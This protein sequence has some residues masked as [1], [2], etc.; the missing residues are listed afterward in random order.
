MMIFFLEDNGDR[1]EHFGIHAS[2]RIST[3]R[4]SAGRGSRRCAN[5]WEPSRI[6]D[7]RYL[8]EIGLPSS[9]A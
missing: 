6:S 2:C 3:C 8:C 1:I 9:L 5:L 7:G 4:G